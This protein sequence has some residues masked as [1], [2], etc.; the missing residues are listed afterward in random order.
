MLGLADDAPL[1]A[2]ALAGPVGEV[3]EGAGRLARHLELLLHHMQFP[4]QDLRESLVLGETEDVIHMVFLAPSQQVLAAE[5]AVTAQNNSHIGP[6]LADPLHDPRD[7]LDA[8]CRGVDVRWS[9][10]G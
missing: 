5:A 10:L 8:A 1:A 4:P 3:L 2:P 7:L 9:Q 6:R